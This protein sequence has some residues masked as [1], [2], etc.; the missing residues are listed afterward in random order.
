VVHHYDI[1]R[2]WYV[3]DQESSVLD[4]DS[5]FLLQRIMDIDA[6]LH[7]VSAARIVPMCLEGDRN[8]FPLRICMFKVP[9]ADPIYG[10]VHQPP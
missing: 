6:R 1:E 8:T 5:E 3:L 4:I 10:V 2:R 9:F 7:A